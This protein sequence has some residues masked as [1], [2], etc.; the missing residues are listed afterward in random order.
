M[1]YLNQ[2]FFSNFSA[3]SS[4]DGNNLTIDLFANELS[5]LIVYNT[6]KLIDTLN[7]VD[8]KVNEKMSDEEIVDDV[9][10]GISGN[11]KVIKAIGFAIAENNGLVNTANGN[12]IDWVKAVNT[13][14][15]GLTPASQEITKSDESKFITKQKVMQQIQ[16]KAKMKGDYT[17]KIWKNES[18]GSYTALW[19]ILGLAALGTLSY[20]IYKKMKAVSESSAI[21]SN[22]LNTQVAAPTNVAATN[23]NHNI[24][25]NPIV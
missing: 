18:S 4:S 15:L 10:N 25:P 19:V 23:M 11:E 14:V 5:D 1:I 9:I 16:T 21:N 2:D 12:Q 24:N 8:V 22:L 20:L 3:G 17:R 7:K 6:H 13:I